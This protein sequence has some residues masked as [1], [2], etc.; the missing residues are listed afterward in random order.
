MSTPTGRLPR[1][2]ARATIFRLVNIPMRVLLRLPFATPASRRLMLVE[3]IGRKTG[4]HYLQPVSYVRSEHS[5]LTPG[6]GRW[7]SNLRTGEAV[8]LRLRGKTVLARPELVREP[9]SVEELLDAMTAQNPSLKRFVPIPRSDDGRLDPGSLADIHEG[10]RIAVLGT[11]AAP[12]A[13]LVQP[14][15]TASA[16]P[17]SALRASTRSRVLKER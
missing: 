9:D 4:K 10:D 17:R 6:G 15:I 12:T 16:A 1:R 8:R 7:T 2:Q 11:P 14:T 3:H 13:I 5:M